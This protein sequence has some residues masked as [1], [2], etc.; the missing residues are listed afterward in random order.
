MKHNILIPIDFSS[1]TDKQLAY[2]ATLVH[3]PANTVI[4]LYHA[5]AL[6]PPVYMVDAHP[7]QYIQPDYNGIRERVEALGEQLRTS[8]RVA[9]VQ[10]IVATGAPQSKVSQL[11]Q[12]DVYEATVI[13]SHGQG[14]LYDLVFG[15]VTAAVLKQANSPVHVLPASTTVAPKPNGPVAVCVDLVDTAEANRH[16]LEVAAAAAQRTGCKAVALYAEPR[17]GTFVITGYADLDVRSEERLRVLDR[18][19]AKRCHEVTALT[20]IAFETVVRFGAPA[21]VL[22]HEIDDL[23][24][25]LLV[26]GAHR[27][28]V[29]HDLILGSVSR[30]LLKHAETPVI[31]ANAERPKTPSQNMRKSAERFPES[32][33][34]PT[35]Y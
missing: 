24:P 9:D 1:V 20:G 35:P 28:G 34:L 6:P 7:L 10:C 4:T 11:V 29:V 18:A 15:S 26:L 22:R 31:V 2:A 13:G 5:V 8:L 32:A 30:K 33:T 19:L 23:E 17:P 3:D 25:S 14:A 12:G 27:N 16:V 21:A